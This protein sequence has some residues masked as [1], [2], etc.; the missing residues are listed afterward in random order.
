MRI[1]IVAPP[2]IP[3]PPAAYGG[4]ELF[5]ANLAEA[6]CD[7]GHHVVVYANGESRV[8]CPVR[9]TYAEADWPLHSDSAATLKG[10]DHCAWA[11]GDCLAGDFDVVHTNDALAVPLSR[12]VQVPVIHTLHHPHEPDLSALYSRYP[13]IMYV[14]I[15]DAQRELE[16]MPKLRT[17]H[18]GLRLGDY[19]F[20]DRKEGYMLF[21]GRFAPVKGAHLAI[22][23]A[24]RA[25]L[26][27]KLAGEIQP[28]FH[29][30]WAR[31]VQPH[32]DGSMVEYV[33]EADHA[34][35]NELLSGA[36]A[37]LFPIQWDEP[38][39]LVMI[40]A[41]ACGTPV[42]ALPGGAVDE[43]VRDGI[44]GWVCADVEEMAVRA[45]D[46]GV[47]P[48]TCREEAEQRF[49]VERMAA[50]YEAVYN[51]AVTGEFVTEPAIAEPAAES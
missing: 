25:G 31:M 49:S 18:H 1:A 40:E 19:R 15:S 37:L 21:L 47:S 4:T 5:V 7:R 2:F 29:D 8:R 14:A 16:R 36:S 9:W 11:M 41:M 51:A 6:L 28:A 32:L 17:V 10:L 23:V 33:G 34:L 39:G 12:F 24:K 22:D 46:P 44:S 30:Y 35:K 43:V 13:D 42:L 20:S 26:P 27:L 48:W 3:V 50:M 38:F 45:A